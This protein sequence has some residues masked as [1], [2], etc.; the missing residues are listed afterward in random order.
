MLMLRHFHHVLHDVAC[1]VNMAIW[2]TRECCMLRQQ[3]KFRAT[4]CLEAGRRP[5]DAP[6]YLATPTAARPPSPPPP[7]APRPQPHLLLRERRPPRPRSSHAAPPAPPAGRPLPSRRGETLCGRAP[8]LPPPA[9]RRAVARA[10]A[11]RPG[12][13]TR[14]ITATGAA[15]TARERR[16]RGATRQRECVK[17]HVGS[18]E[19]RGCASKG[20]PSPSRL[21]HAAA[22][23]V[24][25]T[26]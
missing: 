25:K 16:G 6:A 9:P 12:R 24:A 18:T 17:T 3:G 26:P 5:R 22:F 14:D 10:A 2:K 4:G 1:C 13:P 7:P 15:R 23:R 19:L 11:E 21:L 8:R 20:Y